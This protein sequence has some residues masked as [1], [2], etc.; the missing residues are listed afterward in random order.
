MGYKGTLRDIQAA[1]RRQERESERR[2]K[3]QAKLSAIEQ[4]RLE[5]EDHERHLATLASLHKVPPDIWDW[6][7]LAAALP[8]RRPYHS[9]YHELR[10]RQRAFV[11]RPGEQDERETSIESAHQLDE[12]I[13]QE[14]MQAYAE[15][16][17][18]WD[19]TRRLARRVLAKE[20]SA[21]EE[22]L[23]EFSPLI[24]LAELGSSF[25]FSFPSSSLAE[26]SIMMSD[27]TIIPEE[28]KALTPT[29]KLSVR[30]MPKGRSLQ[31]YRDYI[32]GSVLR[33]ARELFAFLPLDTILAT[34][35]VN[36]SSSSTATTPGVPVLS[37]V[38]PR[39][40]FSQVPLDDLDA[41]E[42]ITH[43]G[44]LRASLKSLRGGETFPAITPWTSPEIVHASV[45]DMGLDD[46]LAHVRQFRARMKAKRRQMKLSD[47]PGL[48]MGDPS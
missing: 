25:E 35:L 27:V 15:E 36:G 4:A 11:L 18:K 22:A 14:E 9:S 8:P 13:F 7:A 48:P 1:Q 10:Q 6:A 44:Q 31:L 38:L 3:E 30:S 34:A 24:D 2:A 23:R 16:M 47:L 29:G 12:R 43:F 21:Y 39:L 28:S 5:V 42:A 17:V 26:C 20:T 33:T 46:L 19:K 40:S 37:V 32:C 41:S 45:E